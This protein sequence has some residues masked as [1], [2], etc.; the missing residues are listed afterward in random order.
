[1]KRKQLYPSIFQPS[2]ISSFY[3]KKGDKSDLNNDRGVFN[4]VKVRSILDKM[5]YDDIYD[6]VDST[7]S[8]RNIGARRHRNIR[9]HLFVINGVLNDV[10][11]N[12]SSGVDV[13]IYD[14]AKCFD[15][16]WYA[17]TSNDLYKAGVQDDK[18]ILVT[19]SNK[20]CKVAVKTPWGGLT[21]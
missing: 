7:M 14:I 3:K 1:M 2:N 8:C 19:N 11:Q 17:E 10:Q 5:I 18:F 12:N 6:Q 4:V 16:M 15:K 9:D 13:G 21:D 20:E